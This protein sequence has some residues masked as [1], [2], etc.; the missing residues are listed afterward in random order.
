M[1]CTFTNI[2]LPTE[3]YKVHYRSPSDKAKFDVDFAVLID[4]LD[5]DNAEFPDTMQN[6]LRN[7]VMNKIQALANHMKKNGGLLPVYLSNGVPIRGRYIWANH[8]A[9]WSNEDWNGK[10]E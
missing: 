10:M 4:F 9:D 3:Q 1:P 5:F 2:L 8:T 7:M 6:K